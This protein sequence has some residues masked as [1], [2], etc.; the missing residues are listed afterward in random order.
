MLT[1]L[2][3]KLPGMK[4]D[5]KL[6]TGGKNVNS[7][8]NSFEMLIKDLTRWKKEGWRVVLLSASRTRASRLAN[9]LR[10]YDLRAF[11]PD[12]PVAARGRTRERPG[13]GQE[14][15]SGRGRPRA[16]GLGAGGPAAKI[17]WSGSHSPLSNVQPGQ[18]L[19]THG[20]LHRGFEYP[21][22]K[23]V[24]ITEGDMFGV[25]K[26]KKRRKKTNYQGKAIQSFSELS[27]GDYV[28]HEEHGLGI[29][30]AS[31]RWSGIRLPRTISRSSMGTAETCICRRPPV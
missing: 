16:A 31:R 22:I 10:E 11:C 13:R 2:D 18:I 5:H 15:G 27:V 26:K 29:T 20:N 24:F 25:E 4:V 3:Q 8:Q 23:F 1:G 14:G 7:Y 17:R 9:D 21:L 19:V 6:W 30:A 28:V 12:P